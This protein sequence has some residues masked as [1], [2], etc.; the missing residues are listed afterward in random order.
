[1]LSAEQVTIAPGGMSGGGDALCS[2]PDSGT[3]ARAETK[4]YEPSQR[5]GDNG[6]HGGDGVDYYGD[7]W[8]W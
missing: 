2:S 7:W 6:V 3:R 1:M 4:M 5:G 8:R